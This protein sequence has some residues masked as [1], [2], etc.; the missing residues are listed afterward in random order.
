MNFHRHSELREQHAFM[1]PSQPYWLKDDKEKFRHRWEMKDAQQ[2]G[3]EIHDLASRIIDMNRKYGVPKGVKGNDTFAIY[4]N[5]CIKYKMQT[6]VALVYSENCFGHA[7]AIKFD[8]RKKRLTIFDLKTGVTPAKIEQLEVY[9]ALFFLEY[10]TDL[11]YLLKIEPNEVSIELRIYQNSEYIVEEPTFDQIMDIYDA[12]IER[13]G[14]VN[15][16]VT[17]MEV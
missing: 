9:A 6:E 12:I 4:V 5:D 16:F 3:T 17:S 11:R 7:D 15:E 13:D 14:W 1:S 8:E 10:A 2:R